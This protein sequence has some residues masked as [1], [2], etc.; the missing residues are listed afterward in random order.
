MDRE[1][2]DDRE[3]GVRASDADRDQTISLLRRH[4]V[5]GRLDWDE[6][7]ERL[8]RA[9]QAR[10]REELQAL[11]TDLPPVSG[12]GAVGGPGTA[13]GP[14]GPAQ[15]P[16]G[17]W[18]GGPWSGGP[19]PGGWRRRAWLFL[20]LIP[21][22]IFGAVLLSGWLFGGWAF[23]GPWHYHRGFFFPIFP[24]LFWGFLLAWL[25]LPRRRWRR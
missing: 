17:P 16:G 5:D 3:Q 21:L 6:F 12:P 11:L 15:Q 19:W 8:E 23:G 13:G 1:R 9:S 24:L 4:H 2:Q 22:A 14:G 7:S 10:T 25:F 18:P 20:P